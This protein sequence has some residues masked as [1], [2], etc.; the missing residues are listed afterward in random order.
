MDF[1]TDQIFCRSDFPADQISLL[2]DVKNVQ[3]EAL[4]KYPVFKF[5]GGTFPNASIECLSNQHIASM[6]SASSKA[7]SLSNFLDLQTWRN[8]SEYSD[9]QHL[10]IPREISA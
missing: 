9:E 10:P 6:D 8:G 1:S 7:V 4:Q 5:F 2:G 3:R